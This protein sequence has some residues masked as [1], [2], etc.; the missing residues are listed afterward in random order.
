MIHEF[1]LTGWQYKCIILSVERSH[2]EF[3]YNDGGRSAAGFNK[4]KTGDCGV[5]AAAIATGVSYT[6][7]YNTFNLLGQKER[8]TKSK[9]SKSSA[10]TGIYRRTYNNYLASLGWKWVS[11][12][13]IG[14]GCQTHLKKDELP[15]GRIIVRLSRHYCAVIDGTI[16]DTYNP[17]RDGTRCVYGYWIKND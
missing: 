9:K 1:L 2:M 5:R 13:G 17:S 16:H 6:E 15:S 7:V 12:M 11:T 8:V 4:S 3:Q 14:T 10:E